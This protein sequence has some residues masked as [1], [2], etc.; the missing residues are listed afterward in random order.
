MASPSSF[1]RT[2]LASRAPRMRRDLVLE[3]KGPHTRRDARDRGAAARRCPRRH[4]RPCRADRARLA[5]D[6]P[7]TRSRSPTGAP[8]ERYQVVVHMDAAVLAD[9]DQPGQSVLEDGVRVPAETSRRPACVGSRIVMP[10]DE[11]WPRGRGRRPDPD[12]PTRVTASPA[13]SPSGL[14]PSRLRITALRRPSHPPP[15]GRRP[16]H[17]VESGPCSVDGI[18][19]AVHEDGPGEPA[20]RWRPRIPPS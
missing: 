15:G 8:G 17:A 7:E 12:D 10:H 5:P 18:T 11:D 3:G 4:R 1:P 20:A 19:G 16:D 2:F 9:P 14:S 6:G 13:P